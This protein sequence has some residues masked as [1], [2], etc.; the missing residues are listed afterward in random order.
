MVSEITKLC[1]DRT[2]ID[3]L[4]HRSLDKKQVLMLREM[5]RQIEEDLQIAV[6]DSHTLLL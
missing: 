2:A 3:L 4:L 5:L 6:A 1:R